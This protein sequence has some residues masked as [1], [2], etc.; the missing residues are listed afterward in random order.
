MEANIGKVA[1]QTIW[2]Q[3]VQN[4]TR[5][6]LNSTRTNIVFGEGNP[7]NP[8]F[9]FVGE[10]PGSEEDLLG[11]PFVGRSGKLLYDILKAMGYQR[12]DVYICNVISCRPP[13]NRDPEADELTACSPVWSSQL[14]AVRPKMIIALGRFAGNALLGS[15]GSSIAV[16]RK[17]IH[18]WAKI[19][20]QVTYHPASMLRNEGYKPD[21]WADF[22]TAMKHLEELKTHSQDAGPLFENV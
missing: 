11:K 16:M 19:P 21:A 10:G 2:E 15:Q 1:L 22:K 20:V 9:A 13:N 8:D 6:S 5:C 18:T 12:K 17:K 4:C 14:L 3:K 7:E